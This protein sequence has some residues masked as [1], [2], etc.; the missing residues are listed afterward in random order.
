MALHILERA[1]AD[2][3]LRQGDVIAEASSGNT[4]IAFSAIGSA[5]GHPVVIFM[6]DFMSD[7]R[8]ALIRQAGGTDFFHSWAKFPAGLLHG[9]LTGGKTRSLL[10]FTPQVP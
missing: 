4:G 9:V 1:Y 3:S 10:Q 7:E 2:G 8:K 5:L 6:P